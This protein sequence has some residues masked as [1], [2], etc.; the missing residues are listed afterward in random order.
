MKSESIFFVLLKSKHTS[1]SR[2]QY[3]SK[4]QKKIDFIKWINE[5][6]KIVSD[7]VGEEVVVENLKFI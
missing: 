7:E 2:I 4:P 3:N 1:T 5:E 6:I